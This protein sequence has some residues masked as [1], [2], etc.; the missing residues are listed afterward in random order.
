MGSSQ[1]GFVHIRIQQCNGRMT[2]TT[3]QG[4]T[5]E[6]DKKKIVKVCKKVLCHVISC[7]M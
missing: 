6:Y 1:E 4:I 3:V 7:D 2:V 5:D